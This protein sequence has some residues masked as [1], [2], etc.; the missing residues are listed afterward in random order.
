MHVLS[1]LFSANGLMPHGYSYLW[2]PGLVWLHVLSDSSIALAYFS[3]PVTLVYFIYKRRDLA[4]QWM[5]LCFGVFILACCATHAMEV[6][7]FWHATYWLSY[8]IKAFTAV[9]SLLTAFLF[10]QPLSKAL[11]LPSPEAIRLE[12]AERRGAEGPRN[13]AKSELEQRVQERT[14]ELSQAN[15]DLLVEIAQ[16]TR[17]D[18]TLRD[19]E[20]RLR[21][22]QN[23]S[24]LGLWDWYPS[25]DLVVWSDEHF[26]IFGIEPGSRTFDSADFSALVYPDDR[27]AFES[28]MR[29]AL[30][31]GG[32]LETEYRI[33]RPDGQ[34]RWVIS[35]GQT[36]C[37]DDGE[38][39]RM[40]GVTLDLTER[41]QAAEALRRSE[42]RFRSLVERVK[43][44]AI[45]MLNPEGMVT[46]WNAGAEKIKGYSTEEIIGQHFSRFYSAEDLREDKPMT[47]LRIAATQGRFE[48]EGWRIRKDGS[49]F[50]A[51]VVITALFDQH[52]ILIGFTRIVRD[53]TASGRAEEAIQAARAEL[54]RVARVTTVGELTA[55]IA[56]EI[57]Q[58]LSAIVNNANASRRLLD[59]KPPDL[60]EVRQALVEIAEAGTRA[61]ELIL[62]I[63]ALMKKSVPE[64]TRLD[65]NQIIRDVFDLIPSELQRH[66]VSSRTELMAVPP[67]VLGD[68]VQLQQVVLNLIINGIEAM[69]S[70]VDRPR[71]L[72]IRS[73]AQE[74]GELLVAVE[75]SGTGLD[76]R[77]VDHLFDAFFTTKTDGL[78]L[79]LS[80]SRSIIEAH[81]GRLWASQNDTHGATFQFTLP[82]LR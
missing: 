35:K 59:M 70:I 23:L 67:V 63:R 61:G 76:P 32:E 33:R 19:S 2:N 34:V 82:T 27:A 71:I 9:A 28:V 78:G 13:K 21:L 17:I 41:K 11:A 1:V 73:K 8:S 39:I 47:D 79:G 45:F 75:D 24:G 4:F 52:G 56:H 77:Y 3:V 48:E 12:I 54:A 57:N 53:L 64:K 16:R 37:N 65:M 6:W 29:H 18:Q 58:P 49:R 55:S 10:V 74:A 30:R 51:N 80:I 26:R 68:R 66:E 46:S 14:V 36:H 31:A 40:I 60:E 42:Q 7:T 5:F 69:T 15:E 38:P 81:N 44:Y 62:R 43:D 25:E 72:L 20:E 50:R 22:A